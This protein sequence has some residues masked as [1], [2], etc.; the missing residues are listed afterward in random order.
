[1]CRLHTIRTLPFFLFNAVIYL[2]CAACNSRSAPPEFE[3]DTS[4]P[5]STQSSHYP[6]YGSGTLYCRSCRDDLDQIASQCVQIRNR[7]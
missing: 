3:T 4:P 1:M 5:C 2:L 7:T 6:K